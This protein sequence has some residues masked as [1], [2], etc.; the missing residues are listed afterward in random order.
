VATT[1]GKKKDVLTGEFEWP[2]DR[3]ETQ[4]QETDERAAFV[5]QTGMSV[6]REAT[7]KMLGEVKQF[8]AW[9]TRH[10]HMG[11]D[12]LELD[13]ACSYFD[14]NPEVL[15]RWS[16]GMGVS[17]SE[18]DLY[19]PYVV[20]R[21]NGRAEGVVE[22]VAGLTGAEDSKPCYTE[23][24]LL[25]GD[26]LVAEL[27][28]FKRKMMEKGE[29]SKDQGSECE[30]IPANAEDKVEVAA[31]KLCKSVTPLKWPVAR[32]SSEREIPIFELVMGVD[33]EC[34][35]E[36]FW[37]ELFIEQ[38]Q[39]GLAPLEAYCECGYARGR[40]FGL[41]S[42]QMQVALNCSIQDLHNGDKVYVT[43]A[44][45]VGC[46]VEGFRKSVG[47]RCVELEGVVTPR[48][49]SFSAKVPVSQE[50]H[51]REDGQAPVDEL[52]RFLNSSEDKENEVQQQVKG[53]RVVVVENQEPKPLLEITVSE[54]EGWRVIEYLLQCIRR[55]AEENGVNGTGEIQTQS[56]L[57][58]QGDVNTQMNQTWE[59]LEERLRRCIEEMCRQH[60]EG[61]ASAQQVETLRRELLSLCWDADLSAD[62]MSV[63]EGDCSKEGDE[64]AFTWT[65]EDG[66][67]AVPVPKRGCNRGRDA[68]MP[69][70]QDA[71]EL[72]G[73]EGR[74]GSRKLGSQCARRIRPTLF[75]YGWKVFENE[76]KFVDTDI[77]VVA[78]RLSEWRLG[79]WVNGIRYVDE[80]NQPEKGREYAQVSAG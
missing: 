27:K 54:D 46:V 61:G 68:E 53:G 75:H 8:I 35:K 44:A 52:E 79:M 49:I 60:A 74:R 33:S 62:L 21:P 10:D 77:E 22:V 65:K 18:V 5:V 40:V 28:Y 73:G 66:A 59:K 67:S 17:I 30:H 64:F 45:W 11:N 72:E 78:F 80:N 39:T 36:V 16:G 1:V 19:C 55:K 48:R 38:V 47:R 4:R 2:Q 34:R 58:V 71:N 41:D 43:G 25:V 24:E 76:V 14:G 9:T 7:D 51:E 32:M 70:G 15:L 13:G 37:N 26:V 50:R 12:V 56:V 29:V 3:V 6:S 42:D 69:D 57:V 20:L 31:E 23:Q 63:E